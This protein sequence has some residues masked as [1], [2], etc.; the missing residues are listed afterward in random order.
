MWSNIN[1]KKG[2]MSNHECEKGQQASWAASTFGN[3]G[4]SKGHG[5]PDGRMSAVCG[6]GG[7]GGTSLNGLGKYSY[8]SNSIG[9]C[10]FNIQDDKIIMKHIGTNKQILKTFTINLP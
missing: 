1:S 6:G 4:C 10:N 5:V 8:V 3:G 7:E 9:Y 2:S